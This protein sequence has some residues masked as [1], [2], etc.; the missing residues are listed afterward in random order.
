LNISKTDKKWKHNIIIVTSIRYCK[1]LQK[2]WTRTGSTTAKIIYYSVVLRRQLE[3]VAL[4]L[5]AARRRASHSL[6]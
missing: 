6:P 2:K 4:Q 1:M 5:E 3:N